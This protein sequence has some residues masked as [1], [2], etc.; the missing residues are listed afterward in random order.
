VCDDT[1]CFTYGDGLADVDITALVAHHRAQ[2]RLATVT[3]VQPPGRYG[4]LQLSEAYGVS[5]FQEKP[6]GDG[7]WINGG[8][9]VLEPEVI[10]RIAGDETI[11]EQEPLKGLAA[12]GQLT[13]YQHTGF[14][15]PMDTLRDRQLLEE[16]WSKEQAPWRAW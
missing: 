1:F 14:W 10:D 2:G 15:Q 12:D 7:S 13:A 11:W 16:L 8:F 6:Q 9:F 4:A 5:G 3:A